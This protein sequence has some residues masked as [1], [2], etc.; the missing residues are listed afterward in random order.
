M[1]M[2]PRSQRPLSHGKR[3][4]W[5]SL[6]IWKVVGR[7]CQV[8]KKDANAVFLFYFFFLWCCWLVSSPALPQS[9]W[10]AGAQQRFHCSLW[11]CRA[12]LQWNDGWERQLKQPE[13]GDNESWCEEIRL[14]SSS[15]SFSRQFRWMKLLNERSLWTNLLSS[16]VFASAEKKL[17]SWISYCARRVALY[18][19]LNQ[20]FTVFSLSSLI[21]WSG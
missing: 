16:Q 2:I 15:L 11:L 13:L 14:L 21:N 7:W 9:S 12:S 5:L 18:L 10:Y 20:R 19:R 3:L 4:T 1:R 8:Q 17:W 6:I